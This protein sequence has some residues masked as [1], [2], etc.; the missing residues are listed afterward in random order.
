MGLAPF[1]DPKYCDLIR[2][3]VVRIFDD[4]SICM[5]QTL[6][7]YMGGLTMTSRKFN[8]LLAALLGRQN[9]QSPNGRWTLPLQSRWSQKT[10]C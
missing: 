4:G 7:N 2:E 3:K 8:K 6:F 10:L 1:G 5:D 9:L